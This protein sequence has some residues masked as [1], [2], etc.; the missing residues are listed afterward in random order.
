MAPRPFGSDWR[1]FDARRLSRRAVL[2]AGVALVAGCRR[3]PYDPASFVRRERSR[4]GLFAAE[5]YGDALEDIVFRGLA[6]FGVDVRGRRVLLKPNMVE[7]A[8]GSAI[9][10]QPSV[11]AAAVVA[12]KRLGAAAVVVAEGPG[13]RRDTEYLLEAT[14]LADHLQAVEAAFVDLNHDDVAWVSPRSRFTGLE[15]IALPLE[16][17]RADLVVSMPKL[18]THHWTVTTGA[19]KNLFG[20][21][22]GAVY[23]WPKN[24]LHQRGIEN[25]ILDLT[26]TIQPGFAIVDGIVGMEGD[27]PIMG[28]AKPVG[29]I[30][31][32]DDPVAVDATCARVMGLAPDRIRYLVDAGRFLGHIDPTRID[33]CGDALARFATPFDVVDAF[34]G[35]RAQG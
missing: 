1:S 23:G 24:V 7:Y 32:G 21:V 5:R 25:S 4:V 33:Q 34:R 13:H 29:L 27:G 10:T 15:R 19:M 31:M 3:P 18:K 20:V 8:P 16:L 11:V 30:A 35:A 14:G 12:F 26:A 28:R 17:L 22:P 2:A 9:N 6:E